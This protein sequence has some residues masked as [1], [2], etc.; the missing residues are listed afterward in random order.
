MLRW[1]GRFHPT[2]ECITYM[3]QPTPP[4][5]INHCMCNTMWR[6]RTALCTLRLS[7]GKIITLS[8][9]LSESLVWFA[10]WPSEHGTC[11]QHKHNSTNPL[12]C[13]SSACQ[14]DDWQ[15]LGISAAPFNVRHCGVLKDI[16]A[17]IFQ[18][19]VHS[20]NV[21]SHSLI[22]Y[23]HWTVNLSWLMTVLIHKPI[24]R[25]DKAIVA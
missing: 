10:K 4:S 23:S 11:G 20:W 19:E 12:S 2:Q 18:S 3:S 13:F 1:E 25:K 24:H 6:P 14:G 15:S 8:T 22:T 7:C 5:R 17:G 21:P 9:T 16:A